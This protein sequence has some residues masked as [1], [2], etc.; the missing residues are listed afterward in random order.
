MRTQINLFE[1][2]DYRSFLQDYYK[3][4]KEQKK[5]FSYRYFSEKAGI[6]APSFLFYVIEGKRNLT[7]G[8]ILKISQAIGFNRQEE[9]Y[10]EYLVFF[11]QAKTIVEKTEYYSRLVEIRKPIDI[12]VIDKDRY[13][14][15]SA[16]YHSVIRE[17][18]TF[19]DF[20][21]DF[22]RLGAFL[23]PQIRATEAKKSIFLLEQ[24]G[25]I[26]QDKDGHFY[27]TQNLINAKPGVSDAFVIEKFQ[28]SMLQMA[29]QAYDRTEIHDRMMTSTTFSISRETFD[30][31]KLRIRE[32]HNQLMEMARIDG[33]P[34][35]AC[36]LT[37]NLFPV[38]RSTKNAGM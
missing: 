20:K 32:L 17:V 26:E 15:Y 4:Q 14:Y 38:S 6:K 1:Y 13:E 34:E 10:F 29:M 37:L 11:N 35:F 5:K 36:Q 8:T 9:E 2:Q 16:W 25:F 22:E 3:E 24:L 33:S 18:V 23:V 12:A 7:K 31:F 28:V 27:Q 30:L 19:F 21:G